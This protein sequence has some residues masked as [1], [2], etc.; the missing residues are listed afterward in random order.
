MDNDCVNQISIELGHLFQQQMEALKASTIARLT[1]TEV[2][3]HEKRRERI[4][5]L[6]AELAALKGSVAEIR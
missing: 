2:Q 3:N 4:C 6:C 5:E 1:P